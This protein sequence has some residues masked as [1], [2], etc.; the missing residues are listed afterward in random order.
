MK[1]AIKRYKVITC[2]STSELDTRATALLNEGW[3]PLGGVSTC[4]SA[5][6]SRLR[7]GEEGADL[8][9]PFMW[10]QAFTKEES[11]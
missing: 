2:D 8:F 5:A 6:N 7:R 10:S 11:N 4:L 3:V 9:P 1:A